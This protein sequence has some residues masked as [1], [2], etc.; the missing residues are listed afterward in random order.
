MNAES[1]V[2]STATQPA[3]CGSTSVASGAPEIESQT[4]T[5]G[6]RKGGIVRGAEESTGVEDRKATR[7]RGI[8]QQYMKSDIHNDDKQASHDMCELSQHRKKQGKSEK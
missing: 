8:K 5:G 2:M 4:T 6:Q 3:G 7:L 1:G